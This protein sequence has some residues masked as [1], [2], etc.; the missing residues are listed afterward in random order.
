MASHPHFEKNLGTKQAMTMHNIPNYTILGMTNL[1][2]WLCF[3]ELSQDGGQ[4][5]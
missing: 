4:A 3:L 5:F 1:M 2:K